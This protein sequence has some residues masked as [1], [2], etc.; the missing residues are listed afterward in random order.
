MHEAQIKLKKLSKRKV[1]LSLRSTNYA[2][3]HEGEWGS[4]CIGP[5]FLDLGTSWRLV[6]SF[7]LLPLYPRRK[8]RR[9]PLDRRLG[10][11]Q[12]RSG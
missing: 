11:P 3:R 10:G 8:S 5:H 6:V 4:G 9:Y 2:L 1:N 7:T 12:S